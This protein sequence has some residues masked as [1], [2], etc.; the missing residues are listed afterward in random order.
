MSEYLA[1]FI[2]AY[3]TPYTILSKQ[4][5]AN[6]IQYL[7]NNI[8]IQEFKA[9]LL[10][11]SKDSRQMQA[12]EFFLRK[13]LSIENL[14][15]CKYVQQFK[16]KERKDFALANYIYIQFIM[17]DAPNSVNLS[18]EC[19]EKIVEFFKHCNNIR[20]KSSLLKRLQYLWLS[21]ESGNIPR[22]I[23]DEAV[24]E[25]IRLMIQDSYRRF[26]TQMHL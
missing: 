10:V 2:C 18:F 16:S 12:F 17:E 4:Q 5:K 3:S 9:F 14:S 6:M 11:D 26:K 23:F 20:R 1:I 7:S 24:E 13:E 19:R 15:F 25:I 22:D 8:L 21:S